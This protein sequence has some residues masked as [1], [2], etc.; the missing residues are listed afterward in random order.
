MEA[1]INK[2][3]ARQEIAAGGAAEVERQHAKGRLTARERIDALFDPGTFCEIDTLVTPRYDAYMDGRSSR[4][5]DGVITGFG[6]VNGRR[7]FV[8]GGAREAFLGAPAPRSRLQPPCSAAPSGC[9]SRSS[10]RPR[11]PMRRGSSRD[12]AAA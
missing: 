3:R 6:Q 1:Y 4:Y 10:S 5:G 11:R 2:L 12:R 7:V 9:W 8:A